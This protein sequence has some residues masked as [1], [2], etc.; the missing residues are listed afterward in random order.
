VQKF[1]VKKIQSLMTL[2]CWAQKKKSFLFFKYY[3]I[4]IYVVNIFDIPHTILIFLSNFLRLN[5]KI[6]NK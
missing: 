5:L 2:L 1:E 6:K 3:N 4:A